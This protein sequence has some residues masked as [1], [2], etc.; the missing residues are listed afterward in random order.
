MILIEGGL[1]SYTLNLRGP[2][3]KKVE[4]HCIMRVAVDPSLIKRVFLKILNQPRDNTD[5]KKK[6]PKATKITLMS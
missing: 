4:K 3:T 5:R 2:T 6:T 1:G